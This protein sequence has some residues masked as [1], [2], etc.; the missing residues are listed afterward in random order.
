MYS[1]KYRYIAIE[2][3]IGAGKTSLSKKIASDI[4]DSKLFLEDI[5]NLYLPKFY[6]NPSKYALI[7]EFSMLYQRYIQ[8]KNSISDDRKQYY[9]SDFSFIKSLI[10]SK[11]TLSEPEFDVFINYFNIFYKEL[12]AP[13]LIIYLSLP[14]KRLLQQIKIR[15]REFEKEV[16]DK[17]LENIHSEFFNY[18]YN[19]HNIRYLIID[20]GSA[21][22]IFNKRQY[23][24]ILNSITDFRLKNG[25]N[26]LELRK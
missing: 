16:N 25:I 12:P 23:E 6:K 7:L 10:F 21:D 15:N 2:G 4:P 24:V 1:N 22:F 11:I 26:K 19:H 17:Y 9:I 18:F 20:A 3:N 13:D 5:N 14:I 8:I